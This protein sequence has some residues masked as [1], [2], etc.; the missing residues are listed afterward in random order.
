MK[1]DI[2]VVICTHN[3][4]DYLEKS[5][6]SLAS[7]T[8]PIERFEIIV[9]DNASQDHTKEIIQSFATWR[10]LRYIYEPNLGLSIAR[11]K[12][13]QNARGD[14]V[15]FLDCDAMASPDWLTRI[16]DR[17]MAIQPKPAAVGGRIIPIWEGKR[18]E[19]LTK[20]L[21]TYVGI[22]DWTKKPVVISKENQY[23]LAG[24]N[25]AYQRKVLQRTG[26]FSVQLGRQGQRLLSN[27]EIF[28]QKKI[29]FMDM[30]LFYDPDI[31]VH[32]HVKKQCLSKSW[33]YKRFYWQGISDVI[34]EYQVSSMKE[35][36]W[37]FFRRFRRDLFHLFAEFLEYFK[38]ILRR[39]TERV[40]SKSRIFYWTGRILYL[41]RISKKP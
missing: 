23:Y 17:F 4:A 29:M 24:S 8:L 1:Y 34:L 21:E 16:K 2:T 37:R 19:W 31:W 26:G 18:P 9:V 7:Q 14:F 27:E 11:N 36:P 38:K 35:E 3:Q 32:H 33:F 30:S 6:M 20:D 15:A 10:N 39:S 41:G 13:W 22:I 5:L 12:G 40:S 28:L 25:V